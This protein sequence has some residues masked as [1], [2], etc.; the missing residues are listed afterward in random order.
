MFSKWN[1]EKTK[2]N[3]TQSPDKL[4][5]EPKVLRDM[6][7]QNYGRAPTRTK[8]HSLLT[9]LVINAFLK[10]TTSQ[11]ARVVIIAEALILNCVQQG[12][13]LIPMLKLR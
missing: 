8:L 10:P 6:C 7:E 12:P 11:K 2:P 13:V 4:G 5:W 3:K 9:H 1:K